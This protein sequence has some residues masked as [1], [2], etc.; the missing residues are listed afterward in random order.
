MQTPTIVLS[1]QKSA[2]SAAGGHLDILIRVQA[3]DLPENQITN[4]TPKRLSVVVDRSGSMNGNPLNEALRC[5]MHISKHLTPKDQMS[6][7]VYNEDVDILV[8]LMPMTSVSEIE[9]AVEKVI[10]GGMTNL[11]GGWEG[12]AEQLEGGDTQTI[13]RVLLLSD[14]QA[15]RGETQI[16]RIEAHC[17]AWADKGVSTT[18][19][20]LGRNFNEDLMLAMARAGGGQ[21]YYGQT[22]EDL[23]DNF[24]EELSLLQAMYLRQIS[25]KLIP[26]QGVIVELLNTTTTNPDGTYKMNDLAW[27]SE[28]WLAFRLHIS[29]SSAG[30]VRDLLAVSIS[31]VDLQG[32]ALTQSGPMLQLPVVEANAFATMPEDELAQRRLLE[33]EFGKASQVLR[34]L[35]KEGEAAAAK[36]L[37]AQMEERFGGHAWL[38]AK[39][40]QLHRL[41][42]EDMEMMIKEVSFSAYRMSNRLVSKQEMRYMSDETESNI[43]SFLR[44]KESEGRGRRTQK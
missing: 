9:Q 12:G 10:S 16:D 43:P 18:T 40:E 11:F 24:E 22:A 14:G 21:Q 32:Q 34:T 29:P 4:H 31:G 1:P 17:K 20:G 15:N 37:M 26:A 25:L 5:V 13:S 8:P 41:A 23:Y 3:P 30:S 36:R 7:V 19:I 28:S 6:L 33:L 2:V 39:M 35:A 38:K 44:K 42:E 27:G